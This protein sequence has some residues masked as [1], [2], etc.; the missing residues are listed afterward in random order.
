MQCSALLLPDNL[1]IVKDPILDCVVN[2]CMHVWLGDGSFLLYIRL[3]RGHCRIVC[4]A[5]SIS[6]E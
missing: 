6:S 1:G 5:Q 2:V 3:W 4:R